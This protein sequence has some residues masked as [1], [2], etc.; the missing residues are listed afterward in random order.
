MQG[1]LIRGF[2]TLRYDCTCNVHTHG[3]WVSFVALAQN[4]N[5]TAVVFGPEWGRS[6]Q[7]NA[8]PGCGKF[9]EN[10][11]EGASISRR[12]STCYFKSLV[13]KRLWIAVI[14]LGVRPQF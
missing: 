4:P 13:C 9:A 7:R 1:G 10:G 6:I 3:V 14:V 12:L 2:S 8:L 11:D 5:D